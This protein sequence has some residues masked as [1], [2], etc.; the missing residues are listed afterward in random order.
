MPRYDYRCKLCEQILEVIHN[1]NE[2]VSPKCPKCDGDMAKIIGGV[3]INCKFMN[4]GY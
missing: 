1:I 4:E 2:E 3:N